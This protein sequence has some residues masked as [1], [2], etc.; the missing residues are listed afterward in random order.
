M[1]LAVQV[2]CVLSVNIQGFVFE[3]SAQR[4]EAGVAEFAAVLVAVTP[5]M[6]VIKLDTLLFAVKRGI[7]II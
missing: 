7:F 5:Y 2:P 4:I 6:I 3:A 1:K